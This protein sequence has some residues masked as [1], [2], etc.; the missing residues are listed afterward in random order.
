MKIAFYTLGCKVNQYETEVLR[1]K[2]NELGY[3]VVSDREDFDIIVINSCTVTA[4]SDRKT[5][6]TVRHFRKNHPNAVI[7]LTGC[8]AQA[9]PED[10]SK[11]CEADIVVGNT[12]ISKIPSL[13]SSFLESKKRIID[14]CPHERN[15]VFNTPLISS[16]AERT[17]AYVKIEDGC[18]RYCTYCIIPKARGAVRSKSLEEIRKE[19]ENLAKNGY[20][21]IVLVGINLSAYGKDED[22][23]LGDVVKTDCGVD[24]IKRVRLGSLEPDHI[25]DKMLTDFKSSDKFCPQFPLSLQSGCDETLKRMN[26]HYDS[27]FYM[28]LITRI[29]SIFPDAAITTDIMVG[30]P[31]E[32]EEEFEKSVEFL[33]KV[34][35]AKSHVFAYSRR[36]GTIAYGLPD[37]VS[38]TEKSRRS[39]IMINAASE[40][41][42]AFLHTL[43][44]KI[45]P[46]LFETADDGFA[47]G[48][49]PNYSKILVSSPLSFTGEIHNVKI[50]EAY[51]DYCIGEI[52]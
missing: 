16:F 45:H 21:E 23:D 49:T 33:K 28:E 46:V 43:V 42:K 52:V 40:C 36:E 34:G 41:E 7:L 32:T 9:F 26:R 19:A 38:R 4:E 10:A 2:F 8:M 5:R 29:R 31:G 13:V 35:F 20:S 37:Q 24:G 11:L 18:E 25:S 47:V 50:T 3:T 48:Y 51:D 12:D 44:G 39:S 30:F 6:Q 22:F 17:R 15:E 1:E 27:A 14:V